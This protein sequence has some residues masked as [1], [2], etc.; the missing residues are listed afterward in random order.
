MTTPRFR[1]PHDPPTDRQLRYLRWLATQTGTSFSP[2]QT[3]GDADA[4]IDR[5]KKLEKSDPA[6]RR[7]EVREVKNQL[8]RR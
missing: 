1:S 8:A 6:E 5:M 2:P 4:E 3:F 7:R